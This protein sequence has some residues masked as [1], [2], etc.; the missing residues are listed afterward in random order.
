MTKNR[1]STKVVLLACLALSILIL[2]PNIP[3][4]YAHAFVVGSDP[5]PFASLNTPPSQVEVDFIDPIDIKHSQIKVLDA[6]GKDVAENDFHYISSDDK[7]TAVSLPPN[8][9][10][11]IYTVDTK[12][13]DETDGHTT[14]NAFVFALGQPIPQNLLNKKESVSFADIVSVYDAIARYP[15]LL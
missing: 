9:P 4:S 6:N 8:L 1:T 3:R 5:A 12:V 10:N 2:V 14:E 7:K 13:L 15:S 11:G